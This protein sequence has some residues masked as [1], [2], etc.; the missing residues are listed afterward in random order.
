MNEQID[1]IIRSKFDD[2]R[3]WESYSADEQ[4][5]I[6]DDTARLNDIR[7]IPASLEIIRQAHPYA[8]RAWWQTRI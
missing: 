2:V 7:N 4:Q 6:K 3:R 5:R 8:V 1:A